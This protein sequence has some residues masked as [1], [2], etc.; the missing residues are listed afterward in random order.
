MILLNQMIILF[1][2]MVTG[3]VCRKKGILSDSNCAG[4]SK[5]V[6]Y[7]AN[8]AL[9]LSAG[10]NQEDALRGKDLA[11][12]A[13][14]AV[15]VY[16]FLI[17]FSFLVVFVLRPGEENKG[18]Y[19]VMTVFSNIGFMGF[20]LI[21]AVYGRQALLFASFFSIPCNLLYYTWCIKALGGKVEGEGRFAWLKKSF[22]IGVISS[23]LAVVLYLTG[24]RV[25]SFIEST[26]KYLADLTAPLAMMVI[27]ASVVNMNIKSLFSDV[28]LLV[29]SAIK[30]III[31]LFA[32]PLIRLMGV[33][34]MLLGVCL[35]MLSTPVG[36]MTAMLSQQYGCDYELASKGV[37]LT[38]VLSVATM[39]LVS[40]ILGI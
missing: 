21:S 4:I 29:F 38:T 39:P 6:V 1:L 14:L 22:N 17:L 24:I 20:P 12:A 28:R 18:T 19:R 36:S 33:N 3:F 5:L 35:V 27:G 10:I 26:V 16:I 37:A 13:A 30:L 15:G 25:P 11:T 8:P 7:V 40:M 23:L 31:P 2:L 34:D 32:L 9:V